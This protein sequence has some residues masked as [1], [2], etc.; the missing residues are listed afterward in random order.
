MRLSSEGISERPELSAVQMAEF[1]QSG[2]PP[3]RQNHGLPQ[4]CPM[5]DS[6]KLRFEAFAR[7]CVRMTLH[8]NCRTV[9]FVATRGVSHMRRLVLRQPVSNK[10]E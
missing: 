3:S 7:R 1:C 10:V 8:M 6:S 4:S 9:S 2:R 5:L